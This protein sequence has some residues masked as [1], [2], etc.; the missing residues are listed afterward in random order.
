M[1]REAV[2]PR[3]SKDLEASGYVLYHTFKQGRQE[4]V[5]KHRVQATGLAERLPA[6]LAARC[7]PPCRLSIPPAPVAFCFSE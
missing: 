2:K 6:A 7:K 1:G 3:L 5:T 4:L